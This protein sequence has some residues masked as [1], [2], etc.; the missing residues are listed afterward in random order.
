M[1]LD[2]ALRRILAG[3]PQLKSYEAGMDIGLSDDPH[4]SFRLFQGRVYEEYQ[5]MLR[6]YDFVRIDAGRSPA[7]QQREVRQL[8]QE[9]LELPRY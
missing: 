9:R 3:R 5:Y 8:L 2:V 6:E 1:P 4:E 7:L